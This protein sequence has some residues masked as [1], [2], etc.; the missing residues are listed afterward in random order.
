MELILNNK[1]EN[2]N[3]VIV[4]TVVI[5][6]LFYGLF[7]Y[8]NRENNVSMNLYQQNYMYNSVDTF[9]VR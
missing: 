8:S 5:L 3:K 6:T 4:M 9:S 1:K 2:T 7:T